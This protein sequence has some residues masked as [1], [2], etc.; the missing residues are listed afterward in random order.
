MKNLIAPNILDL[1]TKIDSFRNNV[2][3]DLAIF[4][5]SKLW[6]KRARRELGIDLRDLTLRRDRLSTHEA[7]FESI[8]PLG[9]VGHIMPGNSEWTPLLAILESAVVGNKSWV[10]LPTGSD[11]TALVDQLTKLGLNESVY[12][13]TDRDELEDLYKISDAVSA[14][15]SESSLEEIKSKLSPQTRFIPW[16]HRI[17]FGYLTQWE[18][19]A[20]NLAAAIVKYEQQACSAPQLVYLENATY[21]QALAF[22]NELATHLKEY[23]GTF[24]MLDESNWAELSNFTETH[25]AESCNSQKHVIEGE[26]QEF[27]IVISNEN[28]FEASVLN[29]SIFIKTI[30][31]GEIVTTLLKHRR[32][33]QTAGISSDET[34][35]S[36]VAE[37]L[38]EAGV[39]RVCPISSMQDAHPL[40]SHDGEFALARFVK[41]VVVHAP[42]LKTNTIARDNQ[43]IQEKTPITDKSDFAKSCETRGDYF[44]KSGGSSGKAILS[45][46]NTADYHLQMQVAADGLIASGLNPEVDR[47]MNLFFGGGLYGG[48]LSFT[49][50]LEKTGAPQ[51]PM[52]GY[53][54]LDFV[55]N[56]IIEQKI[57][58][59]LGM[60]SY[61]V[62]L[63]KTAIEKNLKL[64]VEK[65]YYGGEPFTND[66]RAWFKEIGIDYIRSASYGSV[67]AGPLG[68]QCAHSD[69]AIHHVN[70]TIQKIEIVKLNEDSPCAAG[71]VG[72]VLVTSKARSGV[73]IKRYQLGD[74][75]QWL[76][77]K[78][79][80]GD[81]SPRLEL[82]GRI[83]DVFKF[84][85]S[86]LNARKFA[87]LSG[88][89]KI[90]IVLTKDDLR[91][92]MTVICDAPESQVRTAFLTQPDLY[93]VIE[94]EK[95]CK[96]VIKDNGYEMASSGKLPLLVEKRL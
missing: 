55:L 33:L 79:Q 49:D 10:K 69:G 3:R 65:I 75:A 66:Q 4:F 57:T 72:R 44:F 29:R 21:D 27:R 5:D 35:M 83:G 95:S 88:A 32:F 93:E 34:E 96:L 53:Q 47:C 7:L 19:E 76:E 82:K 81:P 42:N 41:R 31:P 17:S 63:F 59:L 62:N 58:V 90:Q 43:D 46:F 18:N 40:E 2:P 11:T 91:D 1:L 20:E 94:L 15:G 52:A 60:P 61:I 85:G 25:I 50:I 74:T 92:C 89:S 71:E 86:F 70:T 14:W 67:D 54:D 45:P 12:V 6:H 37:M 24:P 22:G 68:Y 64:P 28:S 30:K 51:Y 36:R 8:R 38:L 73:S 78:C 9:I 56:T 80:C 16:G 77:G 39:S 48:F 87:E 26:N 23:Q 84:G 13:F